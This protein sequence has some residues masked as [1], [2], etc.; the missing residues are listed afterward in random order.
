MIL[1]QKYIPKK[2][3]IPYIPTAQHKQHSHYL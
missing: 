1:L 3:A 2:G